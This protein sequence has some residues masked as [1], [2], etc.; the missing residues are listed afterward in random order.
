MKRNYIFWVLALTALF[1]VF[2]TVGFAL[3]YS[4]DATIH[5]I[6]N[7]LHISSF[8][9]SMISL[10]ITAFFL[11]KKIPAKI[12]LVPAASAFMSLPFVYLTVTVLPMGADMTNLLGGIINIAIAAYAFWLIKQDKEN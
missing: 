4:Q 6:G 11:L 2:S 3:T 7:F 1:S 5:S 12:I 9:W 10:P 8:I